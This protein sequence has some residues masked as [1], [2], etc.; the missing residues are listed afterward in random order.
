MHV[1]VHLNIQSDSHENQKVCRAMVLLDVCSRVF[2]CHIFLSTA[3]KK[4][5]GHMPNMDSG[6]YLK[7]YN[8]RNNMSYWLTLQCRVGV[9]K[10]NKD[11]CCGMLLAVPALLF[12]KPVSCA[13]AHAARACSCVGCMSI[14]SQT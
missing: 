14:C 3:R 5:R 7:H 11:E 8:V 13:E 1:Y 9:R 12:L 10:N 2:L 4:T 6:A